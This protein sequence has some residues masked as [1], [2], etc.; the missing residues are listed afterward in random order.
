MQEQGF[1]FRSEMW[2]ASLQPG[3]GRG[4]RVQLF[5]GLDYR[6][7]VSLDPKSKAKVTASVLDFEGK[8][9]GQSS[10]AEDGHAVI[11][12]VQPKKTGLY[13][14]AIRQEDGK[15]AATCAM[16]TGWK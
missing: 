10:P 12:S 4:V 9:I 5:K 1:E 14:V 13:I 8:P 2:T 3:M 7:C 15:K 6:F 16:V 11:L